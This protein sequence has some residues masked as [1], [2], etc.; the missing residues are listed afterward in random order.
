M[1]GLVD[2]PLSRFH[3]AFSRFVTLTSPMVRYASLCTLER[4]SMKTSRMNGLHSDSKGA[5]GTVFQELDMSVA[6]PVLQQ[7]WQGDAF[8]KKQHKLLG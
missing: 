3:S 5:N 8:L 6:S 4:P 1:L 2:C 7:Q